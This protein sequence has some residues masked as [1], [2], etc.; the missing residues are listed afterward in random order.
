MYIFTTA[1]IQITI[2]LLLT[3]IFPAADMCIYD[4][5]GD[6]KHISCRLAQ[7]GKPAG[8]I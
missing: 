8:A 4:D 2:N 3:D 7:R 6:G 5:K 1:L